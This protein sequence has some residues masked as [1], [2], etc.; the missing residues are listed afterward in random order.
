MKALITGASSGLG[1]EFALQLDKMNIE[2]VLVARREDRLKELAAQLKNRAEIFAIDLSQED[3]P[4]KVFEKFPDVDIVINNAGFGVFGGFTEASAEKEAEMIKVNITA[5][6]M[7]TKLYLTKLK[8][9]NRGYILNVASTAAF[10]PG[11]LFSSY[12]ASKAYVLRLTTAIWQELKSEKSKV[13]ISVLCPGPVDTEFNEVAGVRFGIG[14]LS[15]QKVVKI[16]I[17]GMLRG[18]R[19]IVPGAMIKCTR[20][21]S[22]L[23]P[24][25]VS[26]KFVR[27]IQKSKEI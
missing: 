22:K 3:A 16:A 17:K 20:V 27:R 14:A 26:A 15:A 11:P 19:V 10:F 6:H 23:M 5:L 1:R 13:K 2:T 18:K 9:K 25:R 7:L 12:Y 21:L 24:E 8:K 4:K